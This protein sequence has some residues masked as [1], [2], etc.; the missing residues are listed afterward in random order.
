M[1]YIKKNHPYHIV[2]LSIWPLAV[3]F[4]LLLSTLAA[5]ML[6][7]NYYYTISK[8]ALIVGVICLLYSLFGWWYDVIKEAM[9][10][11]QHTKEV[12]H[13]LR[14]GMILFIL[15]EIVLFVCLFCS[16]FY[17]KFFPA[18]ILEEVW[19]A[20]KG[21]WPPDGIITPNP[22]TIPLL[23]TMILL[24]SSTTVSCAHYAIIENNQEITVKTLGYTVLLGIFFI[25][26]QIFEYIHLPFKFT[27]GIFASN[28]YII[29]G[30][31]GLHV[32]LGVLFLAVCYFRAKK[33]HFIKP[34]NHLNF[35]FAVW[36][37]HFVDVVWLF[38]FIFVYVLS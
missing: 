12:Q 14:I 27:D 19:V 8:V 29:T 38:L 2:D 3:S 1:Q 34:N 31:H 15:S 28:F 11:K 26:M 32:I 37:W 35:E 23:N 24:L 33:G 17:N 6:I 18:G 7:H 5:A 9:L 36:Y 4:S 10:E 30:A 21:I 22:W 20:H 13:S 16:F 25:L